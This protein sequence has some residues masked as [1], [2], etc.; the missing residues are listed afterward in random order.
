MTYNTHID[1]GVAELADAQDSGSC[2]RK[3]VEVQLLSPALDSLS[4]AFGCT[5]FFATLF[6]QARG[7]VREASTA[8]VSQTPR[9]HLMRQEIWHP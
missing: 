4:I 6:L 8:S 9:H 3:G 2:P 7:W 5:F 1:A